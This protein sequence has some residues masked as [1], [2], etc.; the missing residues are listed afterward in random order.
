VTLDQSI[1]IFWVHHRKIIAFGELVDTVT[2]IG[3]YKDSDLAHADMWTD[4]VKRHGKL[5]GKEYWAIPRGRVVF[6]AREKLFVIFASS[7]V[8]TD[9]RLTANIMEAFHLPPLQ[10]R[11][12][13][14]PHYDPPGVDLFDD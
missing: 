12:F 5:A 7:S 8:I 6:R 4:V 1:G 13:S 10:C 14:D 3:G 2:E 9:D 11:F